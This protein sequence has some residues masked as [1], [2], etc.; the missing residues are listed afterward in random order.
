MSPNPYPIPREKIPLPN[1]PND[2]LG[3]RP[4]PG[5]WV[6]GLNEPMMVWWRCPICEGQVP[7][8]PEY[9]ID[10][11]GIILCA[12]HHEHNLDGYPMCAWKLPIQL[13]GYND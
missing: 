3:N 1:V 12:S 4:A 2:P 6:M 5:Y 10:S 8:R 7:F 13:I 9:D 11:K